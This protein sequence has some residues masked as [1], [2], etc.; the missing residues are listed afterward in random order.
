MRDPSPS[1][2][3]HPGAQLTHWQ[4]WHLAYD[5]PASSLSRRLRVVRSELSAALG[6]ARLG[7]I[8][9]LSLCAGDGRDLLDVLEGHARRDDVEAVLVE[10]DPVLVD[11]ARARVA[12]LGHHAITVLQ[13]DAGVTGSYAGGAPYDVVLCCGVFGNVTDA[14]VRST[15]QG[16]GA[17]VANGGS[18][19]WTRHRRPPDLTPEIRAWLSEAGFV[20]ESFVPIEGSLGAVGRNSRALAAEPSVLQARLFAFVG[21][22]ADGHS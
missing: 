19:I 2:D 21:D 14:D 7:P 17:L 8:R 12:E 20:E 4:E 13:V 10:L 15:V 22:G 5:D 3:A 1:G 11:R 6:E 9:V 18:V 16:L